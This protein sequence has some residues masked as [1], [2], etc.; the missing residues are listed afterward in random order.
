MEARRTARFFSDISH[1]GRRR[2]PASMPIRFMAALMGMGLTS[3]NRA[4]IR[5]MYLIWSWEAASKSLSRHRWLISTMTW[6]MMLLATEMTPLA[7]R[8]I[9]G[10]TWSSLPDQM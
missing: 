5:S 10:T 6:G 2:G 4:S 3:Q 9:M 7:P 1:R 8:A